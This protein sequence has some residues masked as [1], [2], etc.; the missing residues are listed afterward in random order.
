MTPNPSRVATEFLLRKATFDKIA[1]R[2]QQLK[3]LLSMGYQFGILTAYLSSRTKS[4]NKLENLSL[5]KDLQKLGYNHGVQ[6]IRSEWGDSKE[7][8]YFVPGMAFRDIIQLGMKYRQEAVAYKDS[9]GVAGIYFLYDKTVSL[10][11]DMGS[12]P[13]DISTE[14]NLYSKMRGLSFSFNLV[15]GDKIPWGMNRAVT[16][17]DVNSWLGGSS[18]SV[19]T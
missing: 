18:R 4:Q 16:S 6:T 15:S 1:F 11:M 14:P 7:T 3:K 2:T 13:A 12:G 9:T 17:R 8:S 19:T 10:A 5:M